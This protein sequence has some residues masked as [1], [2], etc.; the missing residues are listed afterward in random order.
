MKPIAIRPPRARVLSLLA[1]ALL[2]PLAALRPPLGPARAQAGARY[3]EVI[4]VKGQD[5]GSLQGAAVGSVQ[6]WQLAGGQWR[7]EVAQV[8][9]MKDGDFVAADDLVL[10]AEDE[11]VFGYTA[12]GQ[13]AAEGQAPPGIPADSARAQ[14]AVTDPLAGGAVSYLYAFAV[15]GATAPAEQP[16]AVDY[17]KT[18]RLFKGG[19]YALGL[20]DPSL[21]GFL[22]L[23]ELR[24]GSAEADLVDRLKIRGQLSALG[25]EQAVDEENLANLLQNFGANF[26]AE[27]IKLGPVRSLAGGGATFYPQRLGLLGNLN[28]LNSLGGGVPGLDFGL[29]DGRISLD[30]SP[31]AEGATY[32]DA[33]LAAGVKV[34][35]K[36]DAVPASP[37]PAWRELS[38]PMGR[39]VILTRPNAAAATASTYYKDDA[40]LDGDDTGDGQSWGDAGVAAPDVDAL[41]G[42]GFPGEMVILPAGS[43]VTAASLSAQY[44]QPLT[45]AVTSSGSQ[46]ATPTRAPSPTGTAQPTGEPTVILA[47]PT[48]GLGDVTLNGKVFAGSVDSGR[49][50]SGA[51]IS[52]QPCNPHQPFSALSGAD[53]AYLLLLPRDYVISCGASVPIEVSKAGYQTF[54]QSIPLVELFRQPRR[55]FALTMAEGGRVYLPFLQSNAS[56]P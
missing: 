51:R 32:R 6:V 44:Q 39:L 31:A 5:L 13:S 21:D 9:E 4:V 11:L 8:D 50:L 22:G 20:A 45:V 26:S 27:P 28:A 17:D 25:F 54:K 40:A 37:L 14:I 16:P 18:T 30:L 19:G 53:G 35:G 24:L 55:D 12:G 23:R 3:D 43:P 2:W 1:L 52:F 46:P 34:D 33:N 56:R 7:R 36:A 29:K 47:T 10:G 49:P 15:A 41:L 42:S 48:P 38:F